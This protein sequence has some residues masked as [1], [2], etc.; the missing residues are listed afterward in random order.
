MTYDALHG[1]KAQD[2]EHS[3]ERSAMAV[4]RKIPLLDI[5]MA[6][7]L[8]MQY[9]LSLFAEACGNYFRVTE[10]TN[11]R[12]YSLYK[13]A[14]ARLDMPE[15]YPLFCTLG[16]DYNAFTS[17][18][19]E[20]FIV[21]HSSLVSNC[22]DAELLFM[23][24]HELGHIKCEHLLYYSLALNINSI[25]AGLGGIATT[26]AVGLQY[27]ILDWNRKAE[28]SADRAGMIAA[29]N[30]QGATGGT[31]KLLG[32]SSNIPDI[33]FSVNEVLKQV[34][35]FEM[36]TVDLVGK[37]LYVSYTAQATHPWSILRLK[38]ITDWYQSGEYEQ[39][40]SK[41]V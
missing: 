27:A 28:Y 20:P 5:V 38:Q 9:Q 34:E 36:E 21:I 8:D 31:M 32:H 29:G 25:L 39:I 11:P 10:K 35:D 23:I 1:L 7:Y 6:K 4:L 19:K 18:I 40:I 15:E 13:L 26:A 3:G 12:I 41:Y 2:F 37:L 30:I 16:Y 24:G 22:T 14:L 33:D 17:G